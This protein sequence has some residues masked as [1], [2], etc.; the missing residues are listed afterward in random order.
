MVVLAAVMTVATILICSVQGLGIHDPDDDAL[1][2][3]YVRFP[4]FLLAAFLCDVLPRVVLRHRREKEG[5]AVA[6]RAVLHERWRPSQVRF[7]F[8]GLAG[9]YVTYATFRNLKNAVPFVNGSL[10][11]D[12]MARLDHTLWLGHDPAQV[13][14]SVFGEG[15]AASAFSLIYV[16]WIGLIPLTLMWAL[17]WSRN[18]ALGSWFVTA[19]AVDWA[20]GAAT[21]FAFPTLGPIYSDAAT[22]D[23]LR[24]TTVTML[25]G[26]MI[27]DRALVLNDPTGHHALQ[28][29]AAFASLHVGLMV[30][31]CLLVELAG[32]RRSLRIV[33][34]AFLA[35]TAVAT[36]YLGWHFFVDTLG[37]AVV[38]AAAVWVAALATGNH[39]GWRPRLV[40]EPVDQPSSLRQDASAR[41]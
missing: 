40:R 7:M 23:G 24:D 17:V 4:L 15:I 22:F 10:W 38:G 9:W 35:L 8:I 31:M 12:T 16:A 27:D 14:H 1:G 13:L 2:P 25:Q 29:I 37:G 21:Y 32:A 18:H 33:A 6:F 20:L 30:T 26:S 5:Y 28:S 3:A 34:W 41:R 11:D 39:V 36:V 19:F